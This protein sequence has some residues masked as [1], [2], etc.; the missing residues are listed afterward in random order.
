M[1]SQLFDVS[2]DL[3]FK[4]GTLGANNVIAKSLKSFNLDPTNVLL[5]SDRDDYLRAGKDCGMV[6]CRI[7]PLNAPRGN[8]STHYS[9]P[10]VPEV[11]D[12]INEINGIS[13]NAVLK[14]R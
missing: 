6:T 3:L 9:V 10:L 2:F 14:S 7:R 1:K 5:V 11:K 8:I 4:D 13:F 12:V